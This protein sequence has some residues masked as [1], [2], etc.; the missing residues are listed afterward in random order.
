MARTA[1]PC[2]TNRQL[3]GPVLVS[4]FPVA[5]GDRIGELEKLRDGAPL[6][7]VLAERAAEEREAWA[8]YYRAV[9]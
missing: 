7:A 2:R 6:E 5:L 9:V 3:A 4:Y 8:D 1:T